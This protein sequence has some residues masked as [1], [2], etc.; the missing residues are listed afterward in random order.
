MFIENKYYRWYYNIIHRAKSRKETNGYFEKHHILP[1]S[2]GGDNSK[3]NLILLTAREHF[4]CHILLIKITHGENKKKMTFA[5]NRMLYGK[6]RYVPNSRIY[7][8]IRK[9]SSMLLKSINTGQIRSQDTCQK[10]SIGRKGK[11]LG[12]Q[13]QDH[14]DKRVSKI[15][16]SK[17][18]E[19][20]KR[21]MSEDRKDKPQT[22]EHINKRQ[23]LLIGKIRTEESIEKYKNCKTGGR[24]PNAKSVSINGIKYNTKKEACNFLNIS[25]RELNKIIYP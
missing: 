10:I 5:S 12:K 17:R 7:E 16:G 23:K 2:L 18:S 22:Q 13:S 6:N 24:N 4:I 11:G 9:E 8:I 21:K 15:I 19:D 1:K 25:L 14:I 20:T 3:D